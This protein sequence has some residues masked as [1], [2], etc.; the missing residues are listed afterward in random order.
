MDGV[1]QCEGAFMKAWMWGIL[2]LGLMAL[3]LFIFFSFGPLGVFQTNFPPV[4]ELTIERAILPRANEIIL[5]VTNG[6]PAPVTVAQVIVDDALWQ[7]SMN[8]SE[9]TISRLG[10]RR[11]VIPY[12]WVE[13]E[14]HE[15]TLL[16]ATGL[17]FSH[18]I[19]VATTSPKPDWATL[20]TFTLLGVY[21]GVI[22]VLLGLL[23]YPF[24]RTLEKKWV[25]FFLC[26]TLGLLA[27]LMIDTLE[28]AFKTASKVA[29]AYQGLSLVSFGIAI[30]WLGLSFLSNNNP[31]RCDKTTASG[32]SWIAFVIALG[33]GLHNLG[34]G[35]AIGSAY[36]IGEISLG[37]FLVVGFTLHNLTEGLGIVAPIAQDRPP[38]K[39]LV[40]YGA[41]AGVPT[42]LGTWI[43]G[44]T[45]GP[46]WITLFFALGAGAIAQVLYE[47]SR[48]VSSSEGES[49]AT[50]HNIGGF[51]SGLAIMYVTGILVVT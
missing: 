14:S 6:G 49:W 29:G 40:L 35:L 41:I 28:E 46:I 24:L 42:I 3:L 36:A 37:A 32:R 5:H 20:S 2:P 50:R 1:I 12:P 45:Y 10:T 9:T 4:E 48:V 26:L 11:I 18:E 21:A 25:N 34:E 8:K 30:S 47:V 19:A 15:I 33:I 17:T 23:F 31:T 51:L 43:G 39:H 7:F 38:L 22:P 27:F 44:F 13:G 16:T